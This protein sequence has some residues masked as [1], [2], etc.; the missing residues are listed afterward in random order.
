[1]PLIPSTNFD[2]LYNLFFK[3]RG[4]TDL[5][6][7]DPQ[8]VDILMG[9]FTKSF[10]AAGGYIAGKKRLID[11]LRANSFSD[12][13]ATS[14]SPVICTQIIEATR[15][16][17]T[18]QGFKKIQ[19]LSENTSYF[20]REL[21]RRGYIIMGAN[22]SPV[23]PLMIYSTTKIMFFG[24]EMRARGI[25]VAVVGFPVTSFTDTRARFCV[26]AGHTKDQLDKV[27]EAVDEVGRM[28]RID[29]L[30]FTN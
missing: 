4:V 3:G 9:T 11:Y 19:Q 5:Y 27:I 22:E 21:R 10:G 15:T 18:S 8:D 2:N 1:M 12:Y 25:A 24:R 17:M 16:L 7:C 26:S 30:N 28:A 29:F 13:Y 6:G 20:R 14:M 23:V